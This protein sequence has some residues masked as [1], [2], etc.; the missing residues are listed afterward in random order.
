MDGSKVGSFGQPNKL[1][2]KYRLDVLEGG[3]EAV[4]FSRSRPKDDT[5]LAYKDET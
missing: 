5:H 4:T 2:N 3:A 1:G